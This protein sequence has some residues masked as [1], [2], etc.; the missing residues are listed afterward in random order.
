MIIE[1]NVPAPSQSGSGVKK[2]PFE[3]MSVGDS[4]FFEGQTS[5]GKAVLAA[6]AY[7]KYHGRKVSCRSEN[8]GVRV[9]RTA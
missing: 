2:Y 7:A 6:R 1:N 8:G 5:M 9:W 4:I 3:D